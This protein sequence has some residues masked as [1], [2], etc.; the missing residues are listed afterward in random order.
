MGELVG[1]VVVGD[2]V[3]LD[4]GDVVCVLVPVVLRVVVPVV[5]CVWVFRGASSRLLGRLR[6][7]RGIGARRGAGGL[8]R[9]CWHPRG[10]TPAGQESSG[11][12]GRHLAMG[13]QLSYV[14]VHIGVVDGARQQG[15]S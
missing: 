8:V 15:V 13:F 5:V 4:V 9:D 2:V 11:L 10:I 7:C 14:M 6:G 1:E 12:F 3:L